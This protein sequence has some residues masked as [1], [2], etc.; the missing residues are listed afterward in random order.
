MASTIY[1]EVPSTYVSTLYYANVMILGSK[2]AGKTSLV[3]CLQGNQFRQREP[4]TSTIECGQGFCELASNRHWKSTSQGIDYET[5]LSRAV[6]DKLLKHIQSSPGNSPPVL[7]QRPRPRSCS[8][9]NVGQYAPPLPPARLSTETGSDGGLDKPKKPLKR[10]FSFTKVFRKSSE[11][12]LLGSSAG[13]LAQE[14]KSPPPSPSFEAPPPPF[15]SSIPDRIEEK[16]REN[17]KDCV[18]GVLPPKVYGKLIECPSDSSL[19]F[20]APTLLTRAP[21]LLVAVDVSISDP[22]L[23]DRLIS[24]VGAL[25]HRWDAAFPQPPK[26]VPHTP[27]SPPPFH[28]SPLLQSSQGSQTPPVPHGN[29]CIVL[30]GTHIDRVRGLVAKDNFERA[31]RSFKSSACGK[32][33]A[34]ASFMMSCSS[35]LEQ[36]LLEDFKKYLVDLVKKR[37]VQEVPLRWLRCIGR[38]RRLGREKCRYLCTA[39]DAADIV[40]EI[41]GEEREAENVLRFLEDNNVTLHLKHVKALRDTILTDPQWF[42]TEADKIFSL[43]HSTA[44]SALPSEYGEDV[45]TLVSHGSLSNRL[46]DHLWPFS[47]QT[48]QELLLLLHS[49]EMV[50]LR[51]NDSRPVSP[52]ESE[53]SLTD[54]A[55]D[56]PLAKR[57]NKAPS[58][59]AVIVP[60]VVLEPVPADASSSIEPLYFRCSRGHFLVVVMPLLAVRCLQMYPSACCLY[61]GASCFQVDEDYVVAI[62]ECANAI[63][64]SLQPSHHASHPNP[65]PPPLP[66]ADVAMATLMFVRATIEDVCSKCMP[67]DSVDVCIRCTC[68]GPPHYVTLRDSAVK[69]ETR[70]CETGSSVRLPP[71]VLPWFG[72]EVGDHHR[73]ENGTLACSM[74]RVLIVYL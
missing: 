22:S 65:T 69:D 23:V 68:P 31:K 21:I 67:Q 18:G 14:N 45:Q 24:D 7:P 51:G 58:I 40:G 62:E 11:K 66:S 19:L 15:V 37:C 74:H 25:L 43:V 46:L 53:I 16:I 4:P 13:N 71:L 35:V 17:L 60:S 34:N 6:T 54:V 8:S 48:K 44:R 9:G 55:G 33:L 38:F 5:E 28:A 61:K 73:R 2:G 39:K 26:S 10:K 32:Y 59:S 56:R 49:L 3:R 52:W 41:L 27:R 29:P 30:V 12:S 72:E 42:V 63:R 64:L 50:G 1:R 36:S 70:V 47:K 57:A 20:L